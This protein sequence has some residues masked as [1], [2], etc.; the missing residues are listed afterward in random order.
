MMNS[1]KD[2]KALVI[3]LIL[4]GFMTELI[5]NLGDVSMLKRLILLKKRLIISN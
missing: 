4:D 5:K 2:M 3:K 1:Q